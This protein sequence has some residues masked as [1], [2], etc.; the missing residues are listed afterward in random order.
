MNDFPNA[1]ED[2][3]LQSIKNN[4][5]CL[6]DETIDEHSIQEDYTYKL[7]A[8]SMK[9]RISRIVLTRTELSLPKMLTEHSVGLVSKE[10]SW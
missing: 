5:L 10:I 1:E 8:R 4:L 9:W 6:R 3:F 7:Q 2:P